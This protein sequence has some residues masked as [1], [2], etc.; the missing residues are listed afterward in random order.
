MMLS[1]F[2][3]VSVHI[4]SN[5]AHILLVYFLVLKNSRISWYLLF[6]EWYT[7][8]GI[9]ASFLLYSI[10]FVWCAIREKLRIIV[11]NTYIVNPTPFIHLT[12]I[13]HGLIVKNQFSIKH[14]KLTTTVIRI[15]I[16]QIF[17]CFSFPSK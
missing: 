11:F 6:P 5:K 9:H 8:W 16:S 17:V 4:S 2:Y 12:F 15:A 10:D 1:M 7:H 3:C 14:G 13:A